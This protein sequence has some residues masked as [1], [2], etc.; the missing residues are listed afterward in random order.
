MLGISVIVI[1]SAKNSQLTINGK[2]IYIEMEQKL[3]DSI[4]HALLSY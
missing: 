3:L 1:I 4:F 2:Y